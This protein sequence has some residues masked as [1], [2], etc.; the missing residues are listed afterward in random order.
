[1]KYLLLFSFFFALNPK[2]SA[3]TIDSL[4]T[5]NDV[6]GFLCKVDTSFVSRGHVNIKI[7]PTD[8]LLK[9]FNCNGLAAKWNIKNW[10]KIDFNSDKL[11]DLLV[12]IKWFDDY[13]V[14]AVVD[15]G[16]NHF[17]PIRL[18]LRSF[19]GCHFAKPVKLNKQQILLYYEVRD[20]PVSKQFYK[21]IGKPQIDTLIFKFG[22][23]IEYKAK[24]RSDGIKSIKIEFSANDMC[25]YFTLEILAN[26]QATYTTNCYNPKPGKFSGVI[27]A[28]KMQRIKSLI[29]YIDL[30]K[31]Q[32]DYL[33]YWFDSGTV[34]L[35]VVFSDG[36]I[37]SINDYGGIGTYGLSHLYN[38][39]SDAAKSENWKYVSRR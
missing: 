30:K 13:L 15:E 9:L 25:D 19:E 24:P 29:S 37:K 36:I 27:S 11:T 33:V 5:D 35:D 14:F 16:N 22:N 7:M 17:N 8:T 23:F 32:D 3:N 38:L 31:L 2:L 39:L 21:F 4:K 18:S 34:K 28:A 12:T 26:G 20:E 10:E 6:L 1:M